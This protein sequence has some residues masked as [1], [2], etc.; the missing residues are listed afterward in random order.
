[1]Q[2]VSKRLAFPAGTTGQQQLKLSLAIYQTVVMQKI[3][4]D[5]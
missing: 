3:S 1:M 5:L 4:V 2:L